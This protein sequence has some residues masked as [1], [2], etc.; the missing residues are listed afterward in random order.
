MLFLLVTQNIRPFVAHLL[1][2]AHTVVIEVKVFITPQANSPV[3][4][5]LDGSLVHDG[6]YQPILMSSKAF[7]LPI[8]DGLVIFNL[9]LSSILETIKLDE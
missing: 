4:P 2:L 7:I 5:T 3:M 6:S 9:A 8:L 1:R